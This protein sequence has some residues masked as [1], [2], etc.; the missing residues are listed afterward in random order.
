MKLQ[1]ITAERER[2]TAIQ[3]EVEEARVAQQTAEDEAER[4]RGMRQELSEKLERWQ[5]EKVGWLGKRRDVG[6]SSAS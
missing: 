6:L 3:W 1:A 5:Q 2:W 4:E